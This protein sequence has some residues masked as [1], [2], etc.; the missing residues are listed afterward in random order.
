M[1]SGSVIRRNR[2]IIAPWH[3]RQSTQGELPEYRRLGLFVLFGMSGKAQCRTLRYPSC[4]LLF[5]GC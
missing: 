5:G 1:T 2:C 3:E 4:C